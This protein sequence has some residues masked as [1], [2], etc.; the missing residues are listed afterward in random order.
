[1]P[2]L[3]W[4]CLTSSS[5]AVSWLLYSISIIFAHSYI[6]FKIV[7]GLGRI[8]QGRHTVC[9]SDPDPGKAPAAVLHEQSFSCPWLCSDFQANAYHR[10]PCLEGTCWEDGMFPV[11][12]P[13]EVSARTEV[14]ESLAGRWKRPSPSVCRH[15]SVRFSL[16][17]QLQPL[18]TK[19]P[20]P[21][22]PCQPPLPLNKHQLI[23]KRSL[24]WS[25]YAIKEWNKDLYSSSLT[26][27]L[28]LFSNWSSP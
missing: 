27:Y 2:P 15:H 6:I 5:H 10:L 21:P 22:V 26:Q 4:V 24:I 1:M 16:H 8:Y 23:C 3:L 17:G 25:W 12:P 7:E 11:P 19:H 14:S 28:L 9:C 20:G 13:G 18:L